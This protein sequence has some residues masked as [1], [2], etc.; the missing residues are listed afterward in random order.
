MTAASAITVLFTDVVG[1]SYLRTTRGDASAQQILDRHF[2]LVRQQIERH[3]GQEVK[4]IGDSFM[5]AFGSARSAVECAVSVERDLADHNRENPDEQVQVRIG[6]NTGEAIEREG[7]FFGASV[8]AAFRIMSKAAGGQI[9]A[10]RAVRQVVDETK[11]FEFVDRGP[12]WLKG[13]P[14]HWRLYEILWG[15]GESSAVSPFPGIAERTPFVG[16]ENELADLRRHLEQA[17]G[18]HGS[19]VM[20]GGEPGIG[21]TRLTEK[22]VTEALAHGFLF[23]MGHCHQMQG[24]HPYIP[25]VE[26]IES[27]V[28]MVE[29]GTLLEALGDSASEIA[30]LVP[31]IRRKFPD[32][33]TPAELPADQ[34]MRHAFNSVTQFIERVAHV[35]PLLLVLEDLHW[36][37]EST[38]LLVQHIACQLG[39]MPVL[40][41][42]TYRDTELA[43]SRSLGNTIE[44]LLRQRLAHDIVLRRFLLPD[45]EDMIRKWSGQEPPVSFVKLI[46]GQTE[47]NPFYVEEILKHLAD[48]DKLFDRDGKWFPHLSIDEADVPRSVRLVIG[49]RLQRLGKECMETLTAAATVG[50]S[51]ESR[52]L[53]QLVDLDETAF[54]D[55]LDEAERGQFIRS[56]THAGEVKFT[57]AHELI[58]QTLLSDI[59]DLR[60]QR[61]HFQ[62]VGAIEKVHADD[63]NEY[64]AELAYH[65]KKAGA[66]ADMHKT[67]QYL[68]VA[69]EKAYG[70]G[71]ATEAIELYMEALSIDM[72]N[73]TQA[74][75]RYRTGLAFCVIGKFDEALDE[76]QKALSIY[77]EMKE[78]E[79]VGDLCSEISRRL[80]WGS[81]LQEAYEIS[82]RGLTAL[83]D[84]INASRCLLLAASGHVLGYLPAVGYE[85]P[86]SMFEQALEMVETLGEKELEGP[87]LYRKAM[88]HRSY[89]Q[90]P[91][92]VDC[93]LRSLEFLRKGNRP[94]DTANALLAAEWGLIHVGH[95]EEA[96]AMER[97]IET[98]AP[99]HGAELNRCIPDIYECLRRV[100]VDGDLERFETRISEALE[101]SV[102]LEWG[103]IILDYL[104]L[105]TAQLWRGKWNLAE[106][107]FRKG[108][109]LGGAAALLLGAPPLLIIHAYT[110]KRD[111]ALE[112]MNERRDFLPSPGQP[113]NVAAWA[114]LAAAIEALAML[115]EYDEVAVLYPLAQE[116]IATG[117]LIQPYCSGLVQTT[118]GIAAAAAKQWGQSQDH[119]ET[120]L[121]QAREIPHVIEQPEVRRWYAQMLMERGREGDLDK[122][123]TLLGEA[124]DLYHKIDMPR[125]LGIAQGLMKKIDSM[126]GAKAG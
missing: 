113:N 1:S 44:D 65:L 59:S 95:L 54:L 6:L 121:K 76:W 111:E 62:V 90:D 73:R 119:F 72:P 24:T 10:S 19:L 11:D 85:L 60:R 2:D 13:F 42:G 126:K 26:I 41:I 15:G 64:A 71:A 57:F 118:A 30:K 77:E 32:I 53:E 47:G 36:A 37:K 110:G 80:L 115:E 7:D 68:Q 35:Q 87:I 45:G 29:P 12:H 106:E 124:T 74:E 96:A 120:A 46:F 51:V 34:E 66:L 122:A 69:G 63:L 102:K 86:N 78:P 82:S 49:H 23:L 4:T 14:K 39:H 16:R 125:H 55:A 92:V 83:G 97:E 20:I 99:K 50:R 91:E 100:M 108:Q 93:A 52:L 3:S 27:A 89:W 123:L 67:V 8:D 112:I 84:K 43:V 70:V 117:N 104:C 9:L 48:S 88:F 114:M 22:V 101:D 56:T 17:K 28:S 5:V 103:W 58:R 31:E 38:M 25:F 81:R 33:P 109:E 79:L 40:I 94:F 105:G 98:F 75:I 61:L 107:T 116:A 18:G 21:K